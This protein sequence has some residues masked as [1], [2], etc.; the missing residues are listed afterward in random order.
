VGV[1]KVLQAKYKG[2]RRGYYTKGYKERV[3]LNEDGGLGCR[4]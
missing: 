2:N 1:G 3:V 4:K